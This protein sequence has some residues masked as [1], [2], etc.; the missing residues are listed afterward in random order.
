MEI[1]PRTVKQYKCH[2]CCSCKNYGGKG[3]D[4]GKKCLGIVFWLTRRSKVRGKNALLGIYSMNNKLLLVAR[5]VM[6]TGLQ[7][8]L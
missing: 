4:G 1:E 2:H 3:M 7:K 5:H 8:C 6:T